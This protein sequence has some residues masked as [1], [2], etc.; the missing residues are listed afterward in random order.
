MKRQLVIIGFLLIT[1]FLEATLSDYEAEF[2][3]PMDKPRHGK[4]YFQRELLSIQQ[5]PEI[6]NYHSDEDDFSRSNLVH[7]GLDTE[8]DKISLSDSTLVINT[9]ALND[10]DL[11]SS[12]KLDTSLPQSMFSQENQP[13]FKFVIAEP[14][15]YN[16]YIKMEIPDLQAK[17]L[18]LQEFF[19]VTSQSKRELRKIIP[20]ILKLAYQIDNIYDQENMIIPQGGSIDF[21]IT[22]TPEGITKVDYQVTGG[23]GFAQSFIAKSTDTIL[24]WEISSPVVLQYTLSRHYL[25]RH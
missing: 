4:Y 8:L 17:A 20:Q 7:S 22:I 19:P 24:R 21:N 9:Q 15:D 18:A 6:M 3:I 5:D 11:F 23:I 13:D 14:A 12:L 16:L 25:S 2:G 10:L 1:V